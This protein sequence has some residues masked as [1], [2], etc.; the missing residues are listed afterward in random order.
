MFRYLWLGAFKE[1][2]ERRYHPTQK[3]VELMR[4]ILKKFTGIDDIILDPFLGS[5]T[6]AIACEQLNRKWIGI[7]ISKEYCEI[8]RRRILGRDEKQLGLDKW[9]KKGGK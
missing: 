6:T 7:E 3:P 5:G 2:P 4:W 1:K 8:A 9:I